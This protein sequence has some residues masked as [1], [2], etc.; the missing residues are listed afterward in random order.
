MSSRPS[1]SSLIIV[2]SSSFITYVGELL[3][4]GDGVALG[5]LHAPELT[6]ARFIQNPFGT[7]RVYRT[8]TVDDDD[9]DDDGYDDDVDDDHDH[10][11]DYGDDYG[12]DKDN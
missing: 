9:D 2:S 4:G 1:S 5:Y 10:D 3:I 12:D 6:V 11:D 8:G 7:G